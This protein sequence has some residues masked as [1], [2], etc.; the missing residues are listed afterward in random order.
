MTTEKLM[1]REK[2]FKLAADAVIEAMRKNGL[3]WSKPWIASVTKAG[4]PMSIHGN[5]YQG[6]NKLVLGI[7]QSSGG[8]EANTWITAAQIRNSADAFAKAKLVRLCSYTK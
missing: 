1:P 8:Y 6:I 5:A 7:L 4:D 3:Q 2:A